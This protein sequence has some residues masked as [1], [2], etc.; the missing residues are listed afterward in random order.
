MCQCVGLVAA[1]MLNQDKVNKCI[2]SLC[3]IEVSVCIFLL[4]EMLY[5]YLASLIGDLGK[6]FKLRVGGYNYKVEK[7]EN[8]KKVVR[9]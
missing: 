5:V 2:H 1:Q 3:Y 4:R 9:A 8:K 6:R 7:F